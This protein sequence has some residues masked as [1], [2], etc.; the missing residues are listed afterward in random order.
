MKTISKWRRVLSD[1]APAPK[2]S[3]IEMRELGRKE[4]YLWIT[5]QIW[6]AED[7]TTNPIDKNKLKLRFPDIWPEKDHMYIKKFL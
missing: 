1:G 6:S 3:A 4:K 7:L 5:Q 2:S